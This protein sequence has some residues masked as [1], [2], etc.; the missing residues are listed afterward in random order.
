MTHPELSR[1]IGLIPALAAG[2]PRITSTIKTPVDP[3]FLGDLF[4]GQFDSQPRPNYLSTANQLRHDPIN[5]VEWNGKADTSR[6]SR[7]AINLRV[8]ANQTSRAVEQRTAGVSRI[9]RCVGLND[10]LYGAAGHRI[11]FAAECADHARSQGLVQ[12]ERVAD[13]KDALANLQFLGCF[14]WNRRSR[15]AGA[16]I[17]RTAGSLSSAT[18]TTCAFRFD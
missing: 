15:L 6:S 16:S 14:Q 12:T 17:L 7:R 18:A 4:L 11:D 3:Y 2:P 10:P 1:R 9:D 8:D 5:R 13:G